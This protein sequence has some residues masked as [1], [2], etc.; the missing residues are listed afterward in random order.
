MAVGGEQRYEDQQVLE[1]LVK[2][3]GLAPVAQF[4]ALRTEGGDD[5][6]ERACPALDGGGR[7]DHVSLPRRAPYR[8]VVARVSGV[9]ETSVSESLHQRIALGLGRKIEVAFCRD[10]LVEEGQVC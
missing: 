4:D 1:P 3:E 8:K 5:V 9:V 2:P 7:V 6:P 10:H